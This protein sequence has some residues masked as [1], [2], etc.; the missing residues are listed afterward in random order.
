MKQK[1]NISKKLF[2]PLD[3]FDANDVNAFGQIK[4]HTNLANKFTCAAFVGLCIA[5]SGA[6]AQTVYYVGSQENSRALLT[7]TVPM[8]HV[9]PSDVGK[10]NFNQPQAFLIIDDTASVDKSILKATVN[11]GHV[12]IAMGNTDAVR[13]SLDEMSK[14]D[15]TTKDNNKEAPKESMFAM[16]TVEGVE[17]TF[18]SSSPDRGKAVKAVLQWAKDK[19]KEAQEQSDLLFSK[20]SSATSSWK[21]VATRANSFEDTVGSLFIKTQYSKLDPSPDGKYDYYMVQMDN[22]SVPHRGW[23]TIGLGSALNVKWGNNAD[24][25]LELEDYG[26][27]TTNGSS[28]VAVDLGVSIGDV[29]GQSFGRSWSYSIPDVRVL[30]YS[31]YRE[32]IAS[33]NHVFTANTDA[34]LNTYNVKP[35]ATARVPLGAV[36]PWN[37]WL[38]AYTAHYSSATALLI[39]YQGKF[40]IKNT[41]RYLEHLWSKDVNKVRTLGIAG[42]NVYSG[43]AVLWEKKG[44]TDQKWRAV[45]NEVYPG[46]VQLRNNNLHCLG[47]STKAV[48]EDGRL[49][50]VPVFASMGCSYPRYQD[51]V[52]SV[53]ADYNVGTNK[54]VHLKNKYWGNCVGTMG[55][56]DLGNWVKPVQCADGGKEHDQL[57]RF[58]E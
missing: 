39:T 22:Q 9:N 20:V 46:Y 23:S 25:R 7:S 2:T 10:I 52:F 29:P 53:I 16:M 57:W 11:R 33:W 55:G 17:S 8:V 40:D 12:V 13:K 48:Y 58:T 41:P 32:G 47:R 6:G 5:S 18:S 34:A 49:K 56:T 54:W 42:D 35:G 14:P 3:I 31:N 21:V 4:V 37:T 28:S 1:L 15:L 43:L 24:K 38:E 51:T 30:D 19:N 45:F 27:T 44:D 26:P 50:A 36:K